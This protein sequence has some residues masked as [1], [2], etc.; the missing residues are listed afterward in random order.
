MALWG[1]KTLDGILASFNKA[2]TD[3]ETFSD[4]NRAESK[5]LYDQSNALEKQAYDK[6]KDAD[7][8]DSVRKKIEDLLN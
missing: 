7:K 3:L 2:V 5:A 6:N 8:A 1:N 4:I